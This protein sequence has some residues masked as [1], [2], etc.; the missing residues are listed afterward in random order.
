MATW[1]TV[2][3]GTDGSTNQTFASTDRI[4]LNGTSFGDN[5]TVSSYQDSTHRSNSS[6]AHQCTTVHVHNTKYLS[7]STVSLN[8]AAS[9]NVN[10]ITTAQCPLKLTFS[11]AASVATS[12]AKFFA[13]DGVTDATAMSG[14]TFQAFEQGNSSWTAANGSGA[15]LS[16]ADQSAATTHNF[17]IGFSASPSSTGAKT[18]KVKASLTY[19]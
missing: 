12:N 7:S 15:A 4:W 8:G 19:V 18:G 2:G 11:D 10:T 5:V 3:Q 13:N 1:A 14:V 16:L 6:D 17:Y 9:A